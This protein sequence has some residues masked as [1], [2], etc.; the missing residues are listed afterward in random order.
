MREVQMTLRHPMTLLAQ[1]RLPHEF[2]PTRRD[3]LRAA[4]SKMR[5]KAS[6]QSINTFTSMYLYSIHFR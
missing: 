1:T 6:I 4:N 5:F 3:N 2:P